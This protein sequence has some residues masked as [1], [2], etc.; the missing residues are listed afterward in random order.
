MYWKLVGVAGYLVAGGGMG[1]THGF[2]VTKAKGF[3]GKR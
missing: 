1:G 2:G 3:E